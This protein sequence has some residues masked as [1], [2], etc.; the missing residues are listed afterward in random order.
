MMIQLSPAL[1]M[2]TP[3][4][5]GLAHFL[6]DEGV[7]SDLKWVVFLDNSGECW[8]YRN[9]DVRALK[10]ITQ[11][12]EYISP[13]YDP[14]DVAFKNM[15]VSYEGDAVKIKDGIYDHYCER[16]SGEVSFRQS[17][18]DRFVYEKMG[19]MPIFVDKCQI[20]GEGNI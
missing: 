6:I 11:G 9:P 10:N 2:R 8:T 7:E 14:D 3:K 20:C 13:Y 1:P 4:G 18:D 17:S 19:E 5:E 15:E 16:S 12:R